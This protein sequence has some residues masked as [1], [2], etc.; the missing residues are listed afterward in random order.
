MGLRWGDV[1]L[2]A[3][4]VSITRALTV[5]NHVVKISAPTTSAGFRSIAL[6]ARTVTALLTHQAVRA[7]E[8]TNASC[9]ARRR[10]HRRPLVTKLSAAG[11]PEGHGVASRER[12]FASDPQPMIG[13]HFVH[14][15]RRLSGPRADRSADGH[16]GR[17]VERG[18]GHQGQGHGDRVITVGIILLLVGVLFDIPIAW[19]VGVLFLVIGVVL[20]LL[21]MAGREIGGRRHYY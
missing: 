3:G 20:A 16:T 19:S 13:Q 2:D 7:S 21:G 4:T 10:R 15:V 1:D 9:W 5:T 6:D 14:G 11:V 12:T 17:S 8:R 18:A